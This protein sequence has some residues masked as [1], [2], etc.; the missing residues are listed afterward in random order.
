LIVAIKN[1]HLEVAKA[2]ITQ[3]ANLEL[4][5]LNGENA[6]IVAILNSR[7]DIV[8]DLIDAR[9]NLNVRNSKGLNVL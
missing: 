5:T 3:G 9:A 2:L 6:L 4:K 8:N 1:G 7:E